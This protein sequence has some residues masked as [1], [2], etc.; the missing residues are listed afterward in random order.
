[1][2]DNESSEYSNVITQTI[3]DSVRENVNGFP[4]ER[5]STDLKGRKSE[6]WHPC[7]CPIKAQHAM[8]QCELFIGVG[9]VHHDIALH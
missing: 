6:H 5:E 9:P 2:E 3:F 7:L 1:M 8:W 4:I